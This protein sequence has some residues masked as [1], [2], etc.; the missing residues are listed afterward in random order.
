MRT[1]SLWAATAA[2]RSLRSLRGSDG[3]KTLD[4]L[5]AQIE[6][7]SRKVPTLLIFEDAQWADP[8]SL[9]TLDRLVDRIEGLNALLIVTY[10]PE[11]AP[12]WI[13]R[14]HVTVLT[15]NRLTRTEIAEMVGNVAGNKPLPETVTLDIVERAG[16]VPLFAEEI[17]KATLEAA[18]EGWAPAC[19][20]ADM[21]STAP[22]LS[23]SLHASLLARLDRLGAAR[24]IVQDGCGHRPR[25]SLTQCSRG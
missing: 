19:A 16:G 13:G 12:A 2:T 18:D 10:R 1:C 9:E 23:A 22:T 21:V 7:L 3:R 15:L 17:T 8:S 24:D 6:G 25:S 20:F 14:P 4:A 5:V 11:F